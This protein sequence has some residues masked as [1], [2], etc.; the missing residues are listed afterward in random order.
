MAFAEMPGPVAG[1]PEI[2]GVNGIPFP[3]MFLLAVM[4]TLT[5]GD[6]IRIPSGIHGGPGRRAEGGYRVGV[7]KKE[8]LLFEAVQI[9][10]TGRQIPFLGQIEFPR[11]HIKSDHKNIRPPGTGFPVRPPACFSVHIVYHDKFLLKKSLT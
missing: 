1:R 11:H 5:I 4:V 8:A 9:W 6:N 7:G 2:F 10:G 3:D